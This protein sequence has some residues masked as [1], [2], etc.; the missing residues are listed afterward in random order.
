[1]CV[2]RDWVEQHCHWGHFFG[3]MSA[4]CSRIIQFNHRCVY[5]PGVPC[6]IIHG[7]NWRVIM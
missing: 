4:V 7:D 5:M 1:M 2:V 3:D 6:R